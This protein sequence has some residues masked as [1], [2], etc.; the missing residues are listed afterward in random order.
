MKAW[1]SIHDIDAALRA[2]RLWLL[3]NGDRRRMTI[4]DSAEEARAR[5]NLDETWSC[6]RADP[7]TFL[8]AS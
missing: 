3:S 4:A 1:T 8:R 2:G 7:E 5:F 6:E